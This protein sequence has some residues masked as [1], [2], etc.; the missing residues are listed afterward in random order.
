[1]DKVLHAERLDGKPKRL[2]RLALNKLPDGAMVA[3]AGEAF[4]RSGS[5]LLPW[6]PAGYGEPKP[7][8]DVTDVDVLT[9]PSILAVLARGYRP[10][11]HPSAA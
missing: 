4:A 10:L 8:P 11:W 3:R 7:L 5:R 1:M 9:P 2:H 6:S